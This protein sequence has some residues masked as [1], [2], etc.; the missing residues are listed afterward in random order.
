MPRRSER[1]AIATESLVE[2]AKRGIGRWMKLYY[3]TQDDVV[4]E[5]GAERTVPADQM[6]GYLLD[7]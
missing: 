4:F 1:D 5:P 6:G 2:R 7:E 3:C